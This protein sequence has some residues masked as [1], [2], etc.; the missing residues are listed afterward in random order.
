MSDRAGRRW[1]LPGEVAAHVRGLIISGVVRPGEFLRMELVAEALG[2]SNA[3]VREGLLALRSEGLV[4]LV[5]R[6]GFVVAAFTRGD[7]RDLFWTQ[8]QLAAEL[9]ARAA[10]NITQKEVARLRVILAQYE[11]AA[12]E[13][14]EERIADLGYAFHR[15][16]NL[17]ADSP[18][19]AGLLGSVVRYMP[20]RFCVAIESQVAATRVQHPL[21][22]AT[23]RDRD[24]RKARSLMEQHILQGADYLIAA[25]ER[26]GLWGDHDPAS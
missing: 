15:Q 6:C 19:L 8:A 9:A 3:P 23:L 4:Q 24:A 21:L 25:L 7:V 18:Q 11:Q 26:R 22:A 13:G 2:V 12:S 1:G 14:D 5:P 20:G 16:I 10:T 17:A